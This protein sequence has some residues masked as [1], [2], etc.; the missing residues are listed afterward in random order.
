[1]RHASITWSGNVIVM[2]PGERGP[3]PHRGIVIE[4]RDHD[5][6]N[7]VLLAIIP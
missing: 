4:A 1:M 3:C 6:P 5:P 7:P 2:L